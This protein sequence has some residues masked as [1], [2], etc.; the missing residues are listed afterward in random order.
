MDS[1]QIIVS[2]D[3]DDHTIKKN[4]IQSIHK[5]I[6]ICSGIS[7]GKIDAI[8]RDM[9]DTSTFDI[10]LLASDDM[11]PIVSGY[12]DI[13]RSKMTEYFPD[14]DGVVW[15]N[16][17]YTTHRLNTLVICGSKYYSRF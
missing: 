2:V 3:D 15:F 6:T 7:N 11:I 9:P 14:G 10:L 1:I 12:D 17:G 4:E 13:I 8:N 16:D 5:N